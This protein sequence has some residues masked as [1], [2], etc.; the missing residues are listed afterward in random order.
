MS[1][2]A[3]SG[4]SVPE[5]MLQDTLCPTPRPAWILASLGPQVDFG[6]DSSPCLALQLLGGGKV[7]NLSSAHSQWGAL[8]VQSLALPAVQ[9]SL[10][11]PL[12][13]T[14][15]LQLLPGTQ[16]GQPAMGLSKFLLK[17]HFPFWFLPPSLTMEI[18]S[19]WLILSSIPLALSHPDFGTFYWSCSTNQIFQLYL[20]LGRS[21]R[22][23]SLDTH[24]VEVFND[25]LRNVEW[26]TK[27]IDK[28]E[29]N[30]VIQMMK[31]G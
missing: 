28:V 12:P 7:L 10:G 4:L 21:N 22:Y 19:R 23:Y 15:P 18:S 30:T 13:W 29:R 2:E 27:K 20:C 8:E 24:T 6:P 16:S 5:L 3:A 17:Q 1:P 14:A 31:D 25:I 9:C 11:Q 26:S